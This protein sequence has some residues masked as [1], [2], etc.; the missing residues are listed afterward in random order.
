MQIESL[1]CWAGRILAETQEMLIFSWPSRRL[2]WPNSKIRAQAL[3]FGNG[4]ESLKTYPEERSPQN[5][6][7]PIAANSLMIPFFCHGVECELRDWC[8]LLPVSMFRTKRSANATA[9]GWA[10]EIPGAW[11]EHHR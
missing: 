9:I 6:A 4:K 8:S 11:K 1:R 7:S 3:H 2:C 10:M 5:Q